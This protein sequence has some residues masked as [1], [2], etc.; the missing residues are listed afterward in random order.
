MYGSWRYTLRSCFA[1]RKAPRS[2]SLSERQVRTSQQVIAQSLSTRAP[3]STPMTTCLWNLH[4]DGWLAQATTRPD[5]GA[6]DH[7]PSAGAVPVDLTDVYDWLSDRKY[8][9]GPAFQGLTRVW[10]DSDQ[11]F[12]EAELPE[13]ARADVARFQLAPALLDPRCYTPSRLPATRPIATWSRCRSH[14]TMSRCTRLG[15]RRGARSDYSEGDGL[16]I[17]VTDPA[18]NAVLTVGALCTRPVSAEQLATRIRAADSLYQLVWTSDNREIVPT[19]EVLDVLRVSDLRDIDDVPDTVIVEC[20]TDMV[21]SFD[22]L[23]THW[24]LTRSFS[25]GWRAKAAG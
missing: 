11:I 4:A 14:R 3:T 25:D 8:D 15:R 19:T 21:T 6:D 16:A 7:W 9:Y 1:A 22:V 17:T 10:R 24:M 12:A 2:R 20:R 5:S 23:A 13:H 18:G